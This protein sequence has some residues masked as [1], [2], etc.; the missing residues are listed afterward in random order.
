MNE[1]EAG[2]TERRRGRNVR[3]K[4]RQKLMKEEDAEINERRRGRNE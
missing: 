3:T 2:M 1:E 4:K